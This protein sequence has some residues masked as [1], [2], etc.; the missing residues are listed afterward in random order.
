V[1]AEHAVPSAFTGFEH[2]PLVASHVPTSWHASSAV[3]ATEFDE[4]HTPAVHTSPVV[5]AS[6]S[7]HAV[8]SATGGAEHWPVV[9]S[10]LPVPWHWSE[11]AQT[12]AFDPRHT[13][14]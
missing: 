2:W 14:D 5:H 3:Q 10:Q 1:P 9:A 7:L 13:P 12:T 6:P 11:A 4:P 8:P